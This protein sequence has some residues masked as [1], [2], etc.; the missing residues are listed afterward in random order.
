MLED[1]N[2]N[3][4]VSVDQVYSFPQQTEAIKK[5]NFLETVNCKYVRTYSVSREGKRRAYI[6]CICAKRHNLT[7]IG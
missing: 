7:E 3:V 4:L 1:T 6:E 5:E 2:E